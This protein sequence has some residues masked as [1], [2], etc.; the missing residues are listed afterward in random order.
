MDTHALSLLKVCLPQ[1]Q[2]EILDFASEFR[3]RFFLSDPKTC[4]LPRRGKP[5]PVE[6]DHS[7]LWIRTLNPVT[8]VAFDEWLNNGENSKCDYLIFDSGS[9][10]VRFAFCELTCS[11]EKYVNDRENQSGKRAKA[12]EQMT[13]T[14]QLI[15]DSHIPTFSI[16][17]LQFVRKLG[18][19]GWRDRSVANDNHVPMAMRNFVRTPGSIAA[20]T[21]YPQFIFG[22]SFEF[23]Q[24][25]H[26]AVLD[27][28]SL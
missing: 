23:I 8:V 15:K 12:F 4:G 5:C 16:S 14:W 2:G 10:K 17:V 7:I 1:A 18:V 27:W 3:G 6:C 21:R 28:D 11:I 22:E 26:P 13:Q 19:F 20:V 9:Q 25:K 24:V